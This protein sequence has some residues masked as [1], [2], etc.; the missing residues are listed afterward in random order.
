MEKRKKKAKGPKVKGAGSVRTAKADFTK[1]GLL[2]KEWQKTPKQLLAEYCQTH[3]KEF[4][5]PKY[6]KIAC[7]T[8]GRVLVRVILNSHD[9][10]EKDVIVVPKQGFKDEVAAGHSAALLALHKLDGAR[11]Y[12][13]KLP[14][15]YNDAWLKLSGREKSAQE[16]TQTFPFPCEK[17]SK[18]FKK[19]HGLEQ[20]MKKEHPPIFTCVVCAMDFKK[21]RQHTVHM[22]KEHPD[23]KEVEVKK[24]QKKEV[25]Q[26]KPKPVDEGIENL[27]A[28]SYFKSQQHRR[29]A[30]EG[31]NKKRKD[32]QLRHERIKKANKDPEVM[33]S[34]KD[35][36][37]I[38]QVI[39]STTVINEGKL[40]YFLI[41]L[42][43]VL[44]TTNFFQKT[45][46]IMI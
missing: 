24:E 25:K 46:T 42:T 7:H 28:R 29:L 19:E 23:F 14:S 32:K 44:A 1:D 27:Q 20:H 4:K 38:E 35:R 9:K 6:K 3:N 16:T 12:E 21:E 26:P 30:T 41:D 15:P 39:K 33:M 13:R 17:C 5:R 22:S 31:N 43:I 45:W 36:M 11:Q 10:P 18:G 2:I 8:P 37:Y 34:E 40:C